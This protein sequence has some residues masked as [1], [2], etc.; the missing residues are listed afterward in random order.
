MSCTTSPGMSRGS[1]KT[2]SDA[3]TSD[4]IATISRR[5]TYFFTRSLFVEP[6]DH[7]AAA[8]VVADV[9]AEVLH[10][11]H[12]GPDRA[13]RRAVR[14]VHLL[15]GVALDLEDQ[16]AALLV[17]EGAALLLDHLGE[18]RVVDPDRVQG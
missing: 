15:R 1:E 18:L 12:P 10:V 2:M 7:E 17:V 6:G 8:V 16:L 3:I 4:G 13:H 14:V 9:R 11:R 5:R